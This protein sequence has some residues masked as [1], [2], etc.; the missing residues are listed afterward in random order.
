[1][2]R[3]GDYQDMR[4]GIDPGNTGAIALLDD[5][6]GLIWVEDMPLM[7][8]GKKQQVNA[9]ALTEILLDWDLIVDVNNTTA[10]VEKVGAMPGQG[11]SSMFNFG[12]GYGVIQGVLAA[13]GIPYYL[14]TPQKWKKAAN[15]IGKEKDN[16]R[17]L[18]QQLYPQASL[19]RKKDIGR[20]D[21]I[22][23][24]RFGE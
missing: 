5:D 12:M 17:T 4:F 20:A 24:A 22:L 6:G 23:I 16:A 3:H 13:T 10:Y 8:N 1:M 9:S 11:V 14:V 18:A 21:A 2:A 19:S 7:A 15:L